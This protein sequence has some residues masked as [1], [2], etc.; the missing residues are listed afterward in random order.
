MQGATQDLC[1]AV[2]PVYLPSVDPV[3][4][5]EESVESKGSHVVRGNIFNDTD[6]V[7]HNDLWHEGNTF[8]PQTITPSK[9]PRSPS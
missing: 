5:V 9:F 2:E 6:L 7:E 8:K 4:D 3:K 1:P